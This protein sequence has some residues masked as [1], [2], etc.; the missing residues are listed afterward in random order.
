MANILLAEDNPSVRNFLKIA[1]CKAGHSVISCRNGNEALARLESDRTIDLLLADAAMP[2]MSG[3][4]LSQRAILMREDLRIMF[5]TG[6]SGISMRRH[7]RGSN[8]S[9]LSRP[10][11]LKEIVR[12]VGNLLVA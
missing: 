1:L 11:H 9:P 6:F 12:E 2:G 10:F 3:I 7:E 5:I 4:E 8:A